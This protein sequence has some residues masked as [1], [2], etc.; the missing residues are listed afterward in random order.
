MS[1]LERVF[2]SSSISIRHKA[3]GSQIFEVLLLTENNNNLFFR[4][5]K[6]SET[7]ERKIIFHSSVVFPRNV[8][9]SSTWM[10]RQVFFVVVVV[11]IEIR[12]IA[13]ISS[14]SV[15]NK[16]Y[17]PS[18]EKSAAGLSWPQATLFFF[19]SPSFFRLMQD[20]PMLTQHTFFQ[21]YLAWSALIVQ[22]QAAGK[23]C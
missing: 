22:V 18:N 11:V 10:L 4:Q 3:V 8:T 23:K 1:S 9:L 16:L 14:A 19:C 7:S 6:C 12:F 17:N 13:C 20:Y 15:G 2:Y 5:G 21:A